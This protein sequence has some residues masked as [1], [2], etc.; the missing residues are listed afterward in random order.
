MSEEVKYLYYSQGT[1]M[2]MFHSEAMVNYHMCI[3]AH[4]VL[5]LL[6]FKTHIGSIK[7]D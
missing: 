3:S 6:V 5:S 7:Y 1:T 2:H 4:L